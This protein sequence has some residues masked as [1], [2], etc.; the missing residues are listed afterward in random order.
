MRYIMACLTAEI[1]KLHH[2]QLYNILAI[3]FNLLNEP[4]TGRLYGDKNNQKF[5]TLSKNQMFF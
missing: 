4:L 1:V 3:I 5:K 2:D